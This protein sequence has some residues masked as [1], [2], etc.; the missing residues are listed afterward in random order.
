MA[1]TILVT[2]GAGY[3]GSHACKALAM[4]GY[5]PVAFDNLSSG[6]RWAVRWGPLEV[7]CLEDAERLDAVIATYRPVAVMHFAAFS[8]AGESVV[9]PAKYYENNV[10]GLLS[11]LAAMRRAG[12]DRLVFSSTAAVYGSPL[13][14]PID[15]D[16]PQQP[17]NPYGATKQAAERV[18][19]DFASAYDIRSVALRYFNAAGADRDG[20]IGE[21]H[22]PETHLIPIV[23]EA[24]AGLRPEVAI[25]GDRYETPDGTCIRDYIHVADLADAH[26]RALRWLAD[27]PGAHAFNLGNGEGFSVREVIDAARRVTGRPIAVRVEDARPGDPAVLVADARC[28]SDVLGW[29]PD[30]AELD[31]QIADAWRW[32]TG[33]YRTLNTRPNSTSSRHRQPAPS[34]VVVAR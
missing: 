28:A 29:R 34:S 18:L 19:A 7:G 26:V 6:H 27:H 5:R 17:I 2:G 12:L 4:A 31:T 10:A 25:F 3:I 22:D 15:E 23:L 1:P 14:T 20:E 13:S 33:R 9:D 11:L 24:A 8:A 21:A 32:L 16:H 30:S